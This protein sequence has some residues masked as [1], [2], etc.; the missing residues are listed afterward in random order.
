MSGLRVGVKT[1]FKGRELERSGGKL[2]LA[3]RA[4]GA[5]G[6]LAIRED[7][8]SHIRFNLGTGEISGEFD[9][10]AKQVGGFIKT[11]YFEAL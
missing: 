3:R 1:G 9:E 8:V 7:E 6:R 4:D 5:G 2:E 10:F 11:P